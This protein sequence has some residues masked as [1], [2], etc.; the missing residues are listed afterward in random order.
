MTVANKIE[1]NFF[2]LLKKN[3]SPSSSIY[4]I[5]NRNTIKLSYNTMPDAASLINQSNIR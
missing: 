4:K 3:F 2:R 1:K 5:F